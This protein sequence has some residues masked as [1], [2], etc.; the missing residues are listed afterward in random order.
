[1]EE[2]ASITAAISAAGILYYVIDA[3]LVLKYG[4]VLNQYVTLTYKMSTEQR[5]MKW[6]S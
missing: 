1:M 5:T 2:P 6:L 4:L 3:V